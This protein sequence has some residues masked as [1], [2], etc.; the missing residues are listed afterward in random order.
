[1]LDDDDDDDDE[2]DL[3]LLYDDD[4]DDEDLE[5]LYGV[6]LCNVFIV[7]ADESLWNR[8]VHSS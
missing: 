4:D 1:M 6:I 2:E 5:L 8:S 7:L 3:E